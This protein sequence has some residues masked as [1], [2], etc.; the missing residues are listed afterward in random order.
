MMTLLIT[1]GNLIILKTN[2]PGHFKHITREI[3]FTLAV[4]DFGIKYKDK[5]IIDHLI[6]SIRKHYPI[7]FDMNPTQYIGI[8]LKWDYQKRELLC[9]MDGY[10]ESALKRI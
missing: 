6:A 4:D 9:S 2:T 7:K 5:A 10:V 8:N 3:S 1:F